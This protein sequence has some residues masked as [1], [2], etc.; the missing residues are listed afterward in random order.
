MKHFCKWIC[1]FVFCTACG[2][3]EA[4]SAEPL[5]R[6]DS[7]PAGAV[8]YT[9][10]QDPNPP[11]LHDP[12][13]TQPMPL[14]GPINT[15]GAEDS[16]FIVPEG[17]VLYFFFSPAIAQSP[18]EELAG[19]VAG[20]YRSFLNLEGWSEP[21]RLQLTR[22]GEQALDGCP[23][24]QGEELWFCSARKDI[25]RGVDFWIAHV[26]DNGFDAP[27][28]AGEL[29]NKIYRI[30]EMRLSPDGKD[31]YFH[32]TDPGGLG[33][34]DI[35]VTHR[36]GDTWTFPQNV[37]DL[38]SAADEGWPFVSP[39]GLELWF[40]RTYQGSPA[41]F[42]SEWNGDSW[43]EPVLVVS[44]FAGEPTLDAAGNLYFVHHYLNDGEFA[45][46]DIYVSHPH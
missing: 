44:Q 23:F 15:A 7:I 13:Y 37:K 2:T 5:Q 10:D 22:N 29:L 42:R 43:S 14:P 4:P 17:D 3:A 18:E 39:S 24:F 32:S 6:F 38:N 8:K 46:A 25:F 30:G 36:E 11:I 20:I 34:V 41:I 9:P 40:T 19:G 27:V 33:G 12:G 28:N 26:Q 35:W 45:E 16:P 31:L 1:V 21:E